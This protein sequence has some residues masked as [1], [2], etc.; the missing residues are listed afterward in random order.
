MPTTTLSACIEVITLVCFYFMS[1]RQFVTR[2]FAKVHFETINQIIPQST[3]N[4][5]HSMPCYSDNID[6]FPLLAH[7]VAGNLIIEKNLT[8]LT[9]ERNVIES[10]V[11]SSTLSSI[12]SLT[13]FSELS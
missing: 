13:R 8:D 11:G 6:Q 4:S 7:K 1:S 3:S 2:Q 9:K 12:S 5:L 10:I